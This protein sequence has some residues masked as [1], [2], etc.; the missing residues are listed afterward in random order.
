MNIHPCFFLLSASIEAISI[1]LSGSPSRS[2]LSVI[3]S[4]KEFVSS[5]TFSS[6]L[7]DS[8]VSSSEIDLNRFLSSS[9]KAAPPR[10]KFLNFLS[11]RIFCSVFSPEEFIDSCTVFILTNS[12]SLSVISFE[13]RVRSGDTSR[14]TL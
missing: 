14:V 3:C 6:N 13:N 7:S 1:K 2:S 10:M 9:F 12:F 4:S 5:R 8:V 11:V